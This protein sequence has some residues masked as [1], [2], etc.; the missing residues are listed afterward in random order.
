M[1]R[2][3]EKIMPNESSG[4]DAS[5]PPLDISVTI[6]SIVEQP[7]LADFTNMARTVRDHSPDGVLVVLSGQLDDAGL[8]ICSKTADFHLS[9]LDFECYRRLAELG[10]ILGHPV[11]KFAKMF[12]LEEFLDSGNVN[13]D[14]LLFLDPDVELQ[15]PLSNLV[16]TTKDSDRV[17]FG[18]E[19]LW[20]HSAH[21][22][23]TRLAQASD[24][25]SPGNWFLTHFPELNTGVVLGRPTA[26]K[27]FLGDFLQF[28]RNSEYFLSLPDR[29]TG[30]WHDQDFFRLW[31][32]E[33]TTRNV[34]VFDLD[35]IFTT[36][37]KASAC[38]FRDQ[39]GKIR[40]IWG[41]TPTIVHFADGSKLRAEMAITT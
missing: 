25:K 36:N 37:G 6:V 15:G 20:A 31:M 9:F 17:F 14:C 2:L 22:P 10:P 11:A 41:T 34:E 23:N 1:A 29:T 21:A 28:V 4:E 39:N 33:A 26:W 5:K 13:S 32:R 27:E 8:A 7:G 35:D 24:W 38:V 19:L 3:P 12:I 18:R 40:T 30:H 16:A